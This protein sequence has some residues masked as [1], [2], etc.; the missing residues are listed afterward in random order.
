V[1]V[2][3][4]PPQPDRTP[5]FDDWVDARAFALARFAYVLTGHED[6]ADE[7]VVRGLA[8]A[9]AR[10][11]PTET[12]DGLE[13]RARVAAV[14]A[15][16]GRGGRVRPT[17]REREEP[18]VSADHETR[19]WSTPRPVDDPDLFSALLWERCRRLSRRE[20][21]AL[22]LRCYEGL[23]IAE[24]AATMRCRRR[25]AR[26][27]WEDALV[28]VVPGP[29]GI[30]DTRRANI[31]RALQQYADRAPLPYS[32]GPRA[33]QRHLRQR[34]RRVLAGGA[35]AAVLVAPVAFGLAGGAT[36]PDAVSQQPVPL[37]HPLPV[38]RT[39]WRW[40]SWGGIQV[41]VPGTWGYGDLTQ[42]C[43]TRGPDGPAVDRPE[44][45]GTDAMC[46]LT[47]N[48]RS[49]Y[50]GGL[51]LRRTEEALRL[52]RADVAPYATS[53]IHTVGDV[54]MTLVDIDPGVGD[55]ILLSAQV[56]GRRDF[57]G[58][59]PHRDV[60]EASPRG[61]RSGPGPL[62]EVG[63]IGSVSV[64]RYGLTGWPDPTLI[65][66]RRL[67]GR[68]A[69]D[70]LAAVRSAPALPR[71]PAPAATGCTPPE[72][73]GVLEFWPR[74]GSE[75]PVSVVVR[76]DGCRGH[77]IDDGRTLRALTAEV[78]DPILVAPWTGAPPTDVRRARPAR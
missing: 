68:P 61:A 65:S 48:G 13:D 21:A 45:E 67:T 55:A 7:I 41:Q 43:V 10:W 64:C 77:G 52:S 9:R 2:P 12:T 76:Y 26:A 66:S 39:G 8:S 71:T 56:I 36:T 57:N 73:I 63:R 18:A 6:E 42:W 53:R 40:E 30:V 51:L 5:D 59:E 11:R 69:G 4:H 31:R 60:V 46:S 28:Q 37:G 22:V 38:D 25:A 62:A 24:T 34:R 74:P 14:R 19:P 32:P 72:E 15:Y 17:A 70:L 49:T 58:C 78:L 75:L 33:T 44:M 29:V 16:L 3:P 20:R 50:T 47:D 1:A 27:A 23:G 35:V 54:T